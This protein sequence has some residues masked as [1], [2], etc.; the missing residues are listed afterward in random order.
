MGEFIGPNDLNVTVSGGQ[1]TSISLINGPVG[2]KLLAARAAISSSGSGSGALYE[3]IVQTDPSLPNYGKITGFTLVSGGTNYSQSDNFS[4]NIVPILRV[5]NEGIRAQLNYTYNAPTEANQTTRTDNIDIGY[6]LDRTTPMVGS[7]YVLGPRLRLV[8]SGARVSGWPRIPLQDSSGPTSSIIEIPTINVNMPA[9]AEDRAAILV[10]GF[11]QSAIGITVEA[12]ASTEQ[13]QS[14]SLVI[15]G[16]TEADLIREQPSLDNLYTFVWIPDEPGDYTIN[17]L[18]RDIAGNVISTPESL[19]TIENFH[20]SGV[21]LSLPGESNYTVEAN[22][23]LLLR[24]DATSE[25]GIAE[26]EFYI[27]E[28]SVGVAYDNGGTS[29]QT[30]VDLS[31]LNLRQGQHQIAIIARDRMGNMGGTFPIHLTNLAQRQNKILNINP[32]LLKNP[33]TVELK[34]P[35]SESSVALGSTLRLHADANDTNG[36]LLGVQFYIN[37]HIANAWAGSFDFND[38][39]PGRR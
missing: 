15:N 30:I 22:S 25:F 16:G 1:V 23:N 19:I 11:V 13:I 37:E 28:Q 5:I 27:N 32:P 10:G 6:F 8:P 31:K 14:V 3:P 12:N 17:A 4:V 24:A 18:V 38:S 2:N 21:N 34:S 29:F 20:G 35:V 26:V 9:D 7:G 39:L 36:D 33:P